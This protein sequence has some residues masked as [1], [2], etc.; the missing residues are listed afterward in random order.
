[1][2]LPL[3]SIGIE[4]GATIWLPPRMDRSPLVRLCAEA[5]APSQDVPIATQPAAT[6]AARPVFLAQMRMV[7]LLLS[8]NR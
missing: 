7:L 8:V 1:M 2:A 6:R 4:I 3:T 5:G